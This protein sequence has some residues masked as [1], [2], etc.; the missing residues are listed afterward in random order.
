MEVVKGEERRECAHSAY[1]QHQP[2]KR[3]RVDQGGA[4]RR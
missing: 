1:L 3:G 2:G 4:Y